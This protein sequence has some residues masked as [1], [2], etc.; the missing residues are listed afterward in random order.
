MKQYST[1]TLVVTAALTA[2]V[3]YSVGNYYGTKVGASTLFT[4]WKSEMR[5]R[6]DADPLFPPVAEKL[7]K[8]SGKIKSINN[9]SLVL[10]SDAVSHN[11]FDEP[12]PSERTVLVDV[13][14]KIVYLK[15]K[16]AEEINAERAAASARAAAAAKI[17]MGATVTDPSPVVMEEVK[18]ASLK[19]GDTINVAAKKD[20]KYSTEFTASMIELMSSRGE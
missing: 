4:K 5:A 8:L 19:V 13:N 16:T 18:L 10:L 14:S 12:A 15:Y 20:I 6:V 11:P 1:L 17:G 2:I 3:G 9:N 7:T